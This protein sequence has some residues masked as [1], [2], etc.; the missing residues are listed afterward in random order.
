MKLASKIRYGT[1]M[2]LDLAM[3]QSSGSVPMSDISARQNI[4][5]KYLEQLIK[6]LKNAGF[7]TSRRGPMGGHMLAKNTEQITL[8]QIFRLFEKE[9]DFE[10]KSDEESTFSDYQD[11][12]IRSAWAEGIQALYERLERIKL[13]D[14]SISTTKEL[15]KGANLLIFEDQE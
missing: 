12:L 2:L 3:H 15:W 4:S 7:V 5:L 8:A 14:L 1:R 11:Y 9:H 10:E 13:S 6:P